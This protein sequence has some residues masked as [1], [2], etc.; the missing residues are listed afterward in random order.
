MLGLPE[1]CLVMT[2]ISNHLANRLSDGMC[3]AIAMILKKVP[4]AYYAPI[5]NVNQ[6]DQER[7]KEFFKSHGVEMLLV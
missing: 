2:T 5:G 6:K 7:F 1:D 4:N 3:E